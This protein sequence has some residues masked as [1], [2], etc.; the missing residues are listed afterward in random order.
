[1]ETPSGGSSAT[2][3]L[4]IDARSV[5]DSIASGGGKQPA[6]KGQFINVQWMREQMQNGV[7]SVAWTDTRDMAADGMTK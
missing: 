4:F 1:M 5:L 7:I 6:E 3:Q 2:I